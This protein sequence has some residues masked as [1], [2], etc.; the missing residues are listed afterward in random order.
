MT[1]WLWFFRSEC[2]FPHALL[3][4]PVGVTLMWLLN[5]VRIAALILI[6]SAGAPGIAAGGFHSQAGWIAFNSAAVAFMLAFQQIPWLR[7]GSPG[8]DRPSGGGQT[9]EASAFDWLTANPTACYLM[10]FLI[11]LAAGMISRAVSS[12]FEWLYPLRFFAALVV[13]W[14]CRKQYAGID[15]RFGWLAAIIGS[16]VFFLWVGPDWVTGNQNGA[17]VI[18]D[19]LARL[20]PA[21]RTGWLA[22]RVLA[23]IVTVPIAEELA[24]RGFLLRRFISADFEAVQPTV[25][26]YTGLFLSSLSFGVLHGDRW[27]A[28]TLAGLLYAFVFLRQGKLG[29]AVAAHAITNGLLAVWVLTRGR[30]YY[31]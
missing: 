13:L 4:L 8:S 15:W 28:G 11:I 27:I 6:G 31:W 5:S 1:A 3:A 2:R 21:G 29:D 25:F 30:W 7:A 19:G 26:T 20:T 22:F 17:N 18:G 9:E 12:G 10:P 24:F 23:A 16:L 14:L